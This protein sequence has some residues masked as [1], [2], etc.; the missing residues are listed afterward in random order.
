MQAPKKILRHTTTIFL[1][2][3]NKLTPNKPSK[4]YLKKNYM[5]QLKS[6]EESKLVETSLNKLKHVWKMPQP[7]DTIQNKVLQKL[8][9]AI[10]TNK[11]KFKLVLISEREKNYQSNISKHNLK[12]FKLVP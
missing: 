8:I 6:F 12:W 1:L 11:S 2:I 5:Y 3:K 7:G 9:K 10:K 4:D